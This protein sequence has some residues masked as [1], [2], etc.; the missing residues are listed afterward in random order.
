MVALRLAIAPLAE[1][2]VAPARL[3]PLP[4]RGNAG[5]VGR[6]SDNQPLLPRAE[7]ER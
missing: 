3:I 1:N 2:V 6:L 5:A 4:A 7:I